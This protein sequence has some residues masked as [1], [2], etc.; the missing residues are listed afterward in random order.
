MI[1]KLFIATFF[2]LA[3]MSFQS[4]GQASLK[5]PL[6]CHDKN[7]QLSCYDDGEYL[8]HFNKA[9]LSNF[10][11]VD[12]SIRYNVKSKLLEIYNYLGSD[13]TSVLP[14]KIQLYKSIIV[15]YGS[16]QIVI[17]STN[18]TG[19]V[20]NKIQFSRFTGP[21]LYQIVF[22]LG[23]KIIYLDIDDAKWT[24]RGK[25]NWDIFI[26]GGESTFHIKYSYKKHRPETISRQD[27]SLKY[28]VTMYTRFKTSKRLWFIQPTFYEETSKAHVLNILSEYYFR[29]N[30]WGKLRRKKSF[31]EIKN[32]ACN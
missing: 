23:K 2:L 19:F 12:S 10:L 8:L 14:V 17:D 24:K 9:Q 5:K 3:A 25:W 32:C 22:W 27:D 30:R 20:L 4:Y 28:G 13:H 6:F 1:R 21:A 15:S 18:N 7:R 26:R 31:G 16:Q 29:Y 11:T